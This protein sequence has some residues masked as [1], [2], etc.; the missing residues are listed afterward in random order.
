[1][2]IQAQDV[3]DGMKI[4]FPFGRWM[5]VRFAAVISADRVQIMADK[6]YRLPLTAKVNVK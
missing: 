5:D 6:T 3:Q 1:M 2:K 4:R